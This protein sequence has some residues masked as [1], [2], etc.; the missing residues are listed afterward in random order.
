MISMEYS[1]MLYTVKLFGFLKDLIGDSE[2]EIKILET[3]TKKQFI[4]NFCQKY[5][6][7]KQYKARLKVSYDFIYLNDNDKIPDNKKEIAVF[8]T[9]SGG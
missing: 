3:V 4:D 1:F 8:P 6:Q 2:V 7:L 9:V 5:P